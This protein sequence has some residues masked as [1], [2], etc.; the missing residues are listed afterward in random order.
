MQQGTYVYFDQATAKSW[1]FSTQHT[2]GYKSVSPESFLSPKDKNLPVQPSPP[3]HS[4]PRKADNL[5]WG[6]KWDKF[7][8]G[9]LTVR[10]HRGGGKNSA[11]LSCGQSW[12]SECVAEAQ[13][14]RWKCGARS[15]CN[16][17]GCI[18]QVDL[19]LRS[20]HSTAGLMPCFSPPFG[21]RE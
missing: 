12:Y 1:C 19:A 14:P 9:R 18:P 16:V 5:V 13:Q 15:V 21:A 7:F 2:R 11:C 17:G 8:D 4:V 10:W 6:W 3:S 20:P